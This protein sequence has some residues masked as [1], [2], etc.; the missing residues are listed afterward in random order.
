MPNFPHYPSSP[1]SDLIPQAGFW[2]LRSGFNEPAEYEAIGRTPEEWKQVGEDWAKWQSERA[3][4]R[5]QELVEERE[6][7][8]RRRAEKAAQLQAHRARDS[9]AED[10]GPDDPRTLI[11]ELWVDDSGGAPA[12]RADLQPNPPYV[13]DLSWAAERAHSE[14]P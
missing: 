5:P 3:V 12:S 10:F 7:V 11:E 1:L 14:V 13:N 4:R 9:S 8:I 6:A 2:G